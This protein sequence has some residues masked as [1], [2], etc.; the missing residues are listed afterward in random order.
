MIKTHSIYI[1]LILGLIAT[2][3]WISN[4]KDFEIKKQEE[5]QMNLKNEIEILKE[6]NDSKDIIIK[7]SQDEIDKNIG[8]MDSLKK[9]Y[10][11][12]TRRRYTSV[13]VDDRNRAIEILAEE[14]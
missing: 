13:S 14:K 10:K 7:I 6:E 4:D 5:I 12:I 11:K 1:V 3:L 2:I 8:Q 9:E